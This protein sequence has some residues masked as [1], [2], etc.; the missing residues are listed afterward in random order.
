MARCTPQ[1]PVYWW[2]HGCLPHETPVLE[3]CAPHAVADMKVMLADIR[4]EVQDMEERPLMTS[5]L[6]QKTADSKYSYDRAVVRI[7]FPDRCASISRLLAVEVGYTYMTPL[8]ASCESFVCFGAEWCC[9]QV[10]ILETRWRACLRLCGSM[11]AQNAQLTSCSMWAPLGGTCTPTPSRATAHAQAVWVH[12]S[13]D[14]GHF[15]GHW[16]T[17]GMLR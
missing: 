8:R 10:S 5:A 13:D 6:R 14:G 17:G 1:S 4:R 7:V 2:R 9:K 3:S 11:C 15:A 12:R 16:K